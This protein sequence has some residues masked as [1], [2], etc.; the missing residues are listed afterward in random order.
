MF[1]SAADD[2]DARPCGRPALLS[3]NPLLRVAAVLVRSYFRYE[4]WIGTVF[5]REAFCAS[6]DFAVARLCPLG[7][8]A[9]VPPP[10]DATSLQSQQ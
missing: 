10:R 8:E 6:S 7:A 2:D 4:L 9:A 3:F 5:E 1:C